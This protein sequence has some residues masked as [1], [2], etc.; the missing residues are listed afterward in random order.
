[1]RLEAKANGTTRYVAQ[2][3]GAGF[4]S[5]QLNGRR[6]HS[7]GSFDYCRRLPLE[8]I[9]EIGAAVNSS[10]RSASFCASRR[11]RRSARSLR[12]LW[13]LRLESG[14]IGGPSWAAVAAFCVLS[15]LCSP[16]QASDAPTPSLNVVLEQS[17]LLAGKSVNVRVWVSNPTNQSL[18]RI[19]L[20]F[21]G[22]EFIEI[23]HPD[24]NNA[25]I[26]N[27]ELKQ[28]ILLSSPMGL[29]ANSVL[30][31][32]ETLCLKAK[33]IVEEHDVNIAFSIDYVV[34]GASPPRSG[35][36]VVEKT[37]SVGLFGTDSVAGVSLRL[38]SYVVPG[39]LLM[40]ALRFGALPWIKGLGAAELGT[41][42]VFISVALS[43]GAERMANVDWL[44]FLF[45]GA[46]SGM[47]ARLFLMLCLITL[48]VAG[49]ID[50]TFYA[51]RQR[52]RRRV[53]GQ[54]DEDLVALAKALRG[55]SKYLPAVVTAKDG[56]RYIGSL[57]APTADGGIA[58]FGWFELVLPDGED[59]LRQSLSKLLND[60]SYLKAL[61]L[62]GEQQEVTLKLASGIRTKAK[63]GPVTPTAEPRHHFR[64]AE[65]SQVQRR[66]V[67]ELGKMPGPLSLA[68]A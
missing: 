64:P 3:S 21:S 19:A 4:L 35:L 67:D 41:V 7:F 50:V 66:E 27:T 44:S 8:P 23:G 24:S 49:G 65:V 20:R 51:L 11:V 56:M 14:P 31:P 37:L 6:Q 28:P 30:D 29:A 61:A 25:R 58:L 52:R 10:I 68:E 40:L 17:A 22:P 38:A 2:I 48:A 55:T 43:L 1:M 46:D 54:A 45:R 15:V 33:Q 42:S 62:A 26:C 16:V 39:L 47:S 32:P 18:S 60:R 53:V 13:S 12:G 59:T 57:S 34:A 36:I 9:A 63:N 5:A